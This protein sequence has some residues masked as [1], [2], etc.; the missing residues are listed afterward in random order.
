[1]TSCSFLIII[2]IYGRCK[3]ISRQI[4]TVV[5]S[6]AL[7]VSESKG[8]M[9]TAARWNVGVALLVVYATRLV[10]AQSGMG[11]DGGSG[12]QICIL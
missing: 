5:T 8:K 11:P 9:A 3:R 7:I 6:H 12:E 2:T 10:N 1:M 4:I